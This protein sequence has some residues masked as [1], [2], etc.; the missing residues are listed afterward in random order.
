M[1]LK[2]LKLKMS[3]DNVLEEN[4]VLFIKSEDTK[5][6]IFRLMSKQE[7][8]IIGFYVKSSNIITLFDREDGKHPKFI[9]NNC[10]IQSLKANIMISEIVVCKLAIHPMEEKGFDITI[11]PHTLNRGTK[12]GDS[13]LTIITT[14]LKA[15]IGEGR[16]IPLGKRDM[17]TFIAKREEIDSENKDDILRSTV[18][19]DIIIKMLISE[20]KLV[21][22]LPIN[23]RDEKLMRVITEMNQYR[24]FFEQGP[25]SNFTT[26]KVPDAP[27]DKTQQKV[28]NLKELS[29]DELTQLWYHINSTDD[30]ELGDM[31]NDINQELLRRNIQP[32]VK[33]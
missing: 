15:T 14:E 24:S 22:M 19:D 7:W 13:I 21:S 18:T 4:S 12:D 5:S 33:K 16:K 28:F 29:F 30:K 20:E 2:E 3:Y 1:S 32:R 31:H 8:N 25:L 11:L 26:V 17:S 23:V 10:S 6:V 9:S 27:A